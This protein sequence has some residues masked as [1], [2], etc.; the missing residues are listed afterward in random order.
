MNFFDAINAHI[1]WKLKL[2]K[3]IDGI[4]EDKLNPDIVCQDNQCK[5]G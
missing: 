3:Y 2:Q 4:S 1:A 5:I